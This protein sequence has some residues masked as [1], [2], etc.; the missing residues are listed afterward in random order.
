MSC[1]P[2]ARARGQEPAR[3][4]GRS[5]TDD[6]PEGGSG[7]VCGVRVTGT[8]C[9]VPCGVRVWMG[10]FWGQ[11]GFRSRGKRWRGDAVSRLPPEEY[12]FVDA[13]VQAGIYSLT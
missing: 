13:M 7:T 6:K 4:G 8:V 9:G 3:L 10:K 1:W 2:A 5:A 12:E 11:E